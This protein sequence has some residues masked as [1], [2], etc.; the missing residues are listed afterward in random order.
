MLRIA[1][2]FLL[3]IAFAA[4]VCAEDILSDRQ[5]VEHL[6]RINSNGLLASVIKLRVTRWLSMPIRFIKC[7]TKI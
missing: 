3:C 4:P 5:R 6:I 1:T 7:C 2:T